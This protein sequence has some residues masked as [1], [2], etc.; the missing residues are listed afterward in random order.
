MAFLQTNSYA[1]MNNDSE[2]DGSLRNTFSENLALINIHR[3]EYAKARNLL[4]KLL[5]DCEE[6]GDLRN[7]VKIIHDLGIIDMEQGKTDVSEEHFLQA[8]VLAKSIG[9][10]LRLAMILGDMGELFLRLGQLEKAK[11]YIN[12]SIT[13]LDKNG[14]QEDI[15]KRWC[16]VSELNDLLTGDVHDIPDYL[17]IAGRF[18]IEHASKEEYPLV[19][20]YLANH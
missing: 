5:V 12:E 18:A 7:K 6:S 3:G 13:T 10:N 15:V 16:Q 1:D 9:Y 14:N 20:F 11:K 4:E 17:N 8:L 2:V 19:Q